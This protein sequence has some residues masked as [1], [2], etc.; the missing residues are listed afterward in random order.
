MFIALLLLL[1]SL[2]G[3]KSALL[4]EFLHLIL[5]GIDLGKPD[6]G[7]SWEL[8]LLIGLS[9]LTLTDAFVSF[10]EFVLLDLVVGVQLLG[11]LLIV[12][13]GYLLGHHILALRAMH[14]AC[15]SVQLLL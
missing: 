10:L 13:F 6:L 4:H 8:S 11:E 7:L 12:A 1:L 14:S 3:L 2:L 9:S 5:R 15:R